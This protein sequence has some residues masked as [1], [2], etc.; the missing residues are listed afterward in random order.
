MTPETKKLLA[1]PFLGALFVVF[2]PLIVW[3]LMAHAI[4]KRVREA[5][6][7]TPVVAPMAVGTAY[8]AGPTEEG[9]PRENAELDEL[10][11]EIADKRG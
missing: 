11:K 4:Y 10:A 6:K 2:M 7:G 8:F 1:S 9:K 3:P 5:M